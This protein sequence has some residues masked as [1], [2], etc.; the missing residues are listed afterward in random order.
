MKVKIMQRSVYHKYAEI[1]VEVPEIHDYNNMQ[2][3]LIDNEDLYTD[4]IDEKISNARY[5]FGFGLENDGGLDEKDNESEWRF[6]IVGKN[7]G[8]HL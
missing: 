8:G 6:D 5:E 7:Y 2:E 4:E 3:Y 1:E